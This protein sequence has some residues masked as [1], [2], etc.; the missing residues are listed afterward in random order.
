VKLLL[1]AEPTM[2]AG[3]A[4][5]D[6][7]GAFPD[8]WKFTKKEL[9]IF[10]LVDAPEVTKESLNLVRPEIRSYLVKKADGKESLIELKDEDR[11]EHEFHYENKVLTE[12]Y[13]GKKIIPTEELNPPEVKK[14]L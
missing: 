5:G 13:S 14:Q 6:V 1:I 9:E 7:V 10:T 11:P 8:D 12:N 3:R 4:L 2:Q